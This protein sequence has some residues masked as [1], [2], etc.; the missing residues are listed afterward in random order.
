MFCFSHAGGSSSSYRKWIPYCDKKGIEIIAI[1]LPGREN[2]I[3]EKPVDDLNA[4]ALMLTKEISHYLDKPYIFFG[5]SM[6]GIISYEVS[7]L[8]LKG[9]FK[10]PKHLF[11]SSTKAPH[12]KPA[13]KGIYNLSDS[14]LI[15]K[16]KDLNGT[17]IELL[18]NIEL[19]SLFLP[20]IRADFKIAETYF[21]EVCMLPIP[22]SVF[23]GDKDTVK[24]SSVLKWK[25]HTTNRF[26]HRI[27][28]GDHF[29]LIKY[30]SEIIDTIS[31][32]FH[33]DFTH[34]QL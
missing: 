27:F 30:T 5:H 29:Y 32:E 10:L 24:L 14:E 9:N 11:I 19:M 7:K 17:P 34:L 6:G 13:S 33:M 15:S 28:K 26:E 12:I 1:Q 20:A 23:L 21:R 31:K 25:E 18:K 8:L 4:L 22:I 16:L 2:R 3:R